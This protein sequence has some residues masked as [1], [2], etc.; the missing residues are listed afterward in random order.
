MI[1]AG[2]VELGGPPLRWADSASDQDLAAQP[3]AYAFDHIES[4]ILA[5]SNFDG[6]TF[7]HGP[8]VVGDEGHFGPGRRGP[9]G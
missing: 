2:L 5:A 6:P 7:S 3:I 9:G 8:T 1:A 4:E